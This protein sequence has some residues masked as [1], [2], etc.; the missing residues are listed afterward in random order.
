M[1]RTLFELSAEILALDT[2]LDDLDDSSQLETITAYLETLTIERDEKLD[3]Y[4]ALISELEARATARMTEA[5]RL[6]ALARTDENKAQRLKERLKL[7]FETHGLEWVNTTRY[8]LSIT[9]NGGNTLS[10]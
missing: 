9:K 2:A 6:T 10:V 8:R 4:A 7:F 1:T 3:G 5:K